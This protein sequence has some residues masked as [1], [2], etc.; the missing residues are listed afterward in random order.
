MLRQDNHD[1]APDKELIAR[2]DLAR[3][4][5]VVP[6]SLVEQWQDELWDRFQLRFEIITRETIEA[7]R[8]G[9]AMAEKDLVIVRLEHLARNDELQAKLAQTEWDLIVADEAHKMSAHYFGNEVKETKRYQLGRKLSSLTRHFLLLMA[10]PHRGKEQD[11]QLFMALLDEDRFEGRFRDGVLTVDIS[12]LM[13][14]L[15]KEE[16]YK[17]DGRPLFPERRAYSVE[18]KLSDEEAKL[19]QE[20][21]DYVR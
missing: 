6:G 20:V 21:T 3:C 19:N 4:L 12:D 2:G 13:R 10:T 17:F 18:Y 14:R 9:N 5:I 1:R 15:V 16:L 8:S 11:F 7:S